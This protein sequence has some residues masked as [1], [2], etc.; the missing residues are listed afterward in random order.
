LP[1]TQYWRNK[2]QPL[3]EQ[4]NENLKKQASPAVDNQHQSQPEITNAEKASATE[5]NDGNEQLPVP[6]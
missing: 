4:A 5:I 1:D 2:I 6:E 3:F